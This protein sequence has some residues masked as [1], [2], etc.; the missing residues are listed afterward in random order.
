MY[1]GIWGEKAEK[2]KEKDW[3]QLLA[4]VPIFK[5]KPKLSNCFQS[6]WIILYVYQQR[7]R[8][9][10]APNP[11]QAL[12]LSIFFILAIL[13]GVGLESTLFIYLFIYW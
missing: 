13:V 2:K 8:V 11:H 3:Q 10:V 6:S 4:Q 1:W 12:L 7:M 5:K 9:S